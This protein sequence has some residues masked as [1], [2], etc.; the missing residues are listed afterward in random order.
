MCNETWGARAARATRT[1]NTASCWECAV[2]KIEFAPVEE[3]TVLLLFNGMPGITVSG[4][5][6]A[7]ESAR[8]RQTFGDTDNLKIFVGSRATPFIFP[9]AS[10][11]KIFDD[12]GIVW[13]RFD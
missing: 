8:V 7:F 10:I 4:A 2:R 1:V 6:V 5:T 13:R 11:V 3:A 12:D 9:H